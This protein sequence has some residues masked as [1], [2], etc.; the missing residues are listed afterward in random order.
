MTWLIALLFSA[1][2]APIAEY[3]A[4]RWLMHKQ[5]GN[6]ATIWKEHAVEHHGKG[7]NDINIDLDALSV[8]IGSAPL[9]GFAYFLGLPWVIVILFFSIV[10]ASLWS[11]IHAA[12]HELRDSWATRLGIYKIWRDHHMRH[13]DDTKSNFGTVFIFTDMLF[14]TLYKNK[15]KDGD[16]SAAV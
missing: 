9:L 7:R 2:Y 15:S 1:M 12:H 4:H 11:S 8:L 6:L 14:G 16:I 3:T 5:F 13:H 10:Y